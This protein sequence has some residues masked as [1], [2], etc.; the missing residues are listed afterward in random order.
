M[1][2]FIPYVL[3]LYYMETNSQEEKKNL[4]VL[5]KVTGGAAEGGEGTERSKAAGAPPRRAARW[6]LPIR[7]GAG[8]QELGSQEPGCSPQA[9]PEGDHLVLMQGSLKSK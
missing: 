9:L 2:I 3:S 1:K 4:N 8:E 6:E 7:A 5:I